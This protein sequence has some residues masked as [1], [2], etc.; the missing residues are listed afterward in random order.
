V[1][2]QDF[3]IKPP[4]DTLFSQK[5]T[6]ILIYKIRE[7]NLKVAVTARLTDA[8]CLVPHRTSN[9]AASLLTAMLL[10]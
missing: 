6:S 10:A 2:T 5:G 3:N 9:I 8:G 1:R 7:K 4:A